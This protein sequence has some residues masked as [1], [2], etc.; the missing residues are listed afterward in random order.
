MDLPAAALTFRPYGLAHWVIVFLTIL[1]AVLLVRLGRRHRNTPAGETFTRTFAI[2]QLM[3][4]LGFMI[5]WLV[6]SVMASVR[7]TAS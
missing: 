3:V 1:G 4:T 7:A 5:V 6:P 2:V